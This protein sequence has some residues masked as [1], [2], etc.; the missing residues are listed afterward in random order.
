MTSAS[1][2][3]L[4]RRRLLGLRLR[5]SAMLALVA[6]PL[7]AGAALL[8]A[9]RWALPISS[10]AGWSLVLLP[11]LLVAVA[12]AV[13]G[14]RR[15][16]LPRLLRRLDAAFPETEDSSAL[17]LHD[18]LPGGSLPA[19]Q[20][21]IVRDRLAATLQ[22]P[23]ALR[24]T[25]RPAPN[26]VRLAA[27]WL[28]GAVLIA[29]AIWV[30]AARQTA[31][32][33]ASPQPPKTAATTLLQTVLTV[34]PPAYTGLGVQTLTSPDAA[35]DAKVPAGS[36]VDWSL[37]IDR[38][39]DGAALVWND[40]SRT[41]LVRGS[42]GSSGA[43][44]WQGSRTIDASAL[45]R[46]ELRGAASLVGDPL[47]RID[48][49]PDA[50]PEIS[51]SVPDK[52]LNLLAEG[53]T[54]WAIAFDARDD[55]GL[56]PATLTITLAQGSGEQIKVTGQTRVLEGSGDARHRSYRQ[57]LDL[58]TLGF[59][60][61][62]DL[63]V[64]LDVADNHAPEAQHTSSAG[65]ILRRPADAAAESAGM[66]GLVQ[67]VLPA[68]FRS[69]RQI[70]I[71]TE[72]LIAAQDQLPE[73]TIAA[74]ADGLGVDQK[75][76]R[77][78]YGQFLGEGF[79]SNAERAPPGREA[80]AANR[81]P[82]GAEPGRTAS[83]PDPAGA[84]VDAA[85][86]AALRTRPPEA[87]P[88]P[89]AA[90]PDGKGGRGDVLAEFGHVHD[91][92]EAATLLDPQTQRIL[93]EALG[94]MWQAELMLRQARLREALPFEAKAL[95]AIKQV[96]QAERIYVARAGQ[97]LPQADAARRLSGERKGLTDRDQP[98]PRPEATDSPVPAMWAALA[99]GERPSPEALAALAAWARRPAATGQH[100]DPLALQAAADRLQRAPDCTDCRDALQAALWPLLP[101]PPT[102]VLPRAAPNAIGR[103]YLD[104][105][106]GDAS[107]RA[108]RGRPAEAR[109]P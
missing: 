58:S 45:Y 42:I 65:F 7:A 103:A 27:A 52:T 32:K 89:N 6:M 69:E 31:A 11:P 48:A 107:S 100:A 44:Q 70:I 1:L 10:P 23:A 81:P 55:Y 59:A 91:Q 12:A 95:E 68:Y 9:Q 109:Q 53:Q 33:S 22:D 13:V 43:R 24:R 54:Q 37:A 15:H 87:E 60:K 51:V 77:L 75:V 64:R 63:I 79:E 30:P 50:P 38:D 61:G 4:V 36:R 108:A 49:V 56:G 74:R 57:A 94:A 34:T 88:A 80:A 21:T 26:G 29:A 82:S 96:Q 20:Q 35:L 71:D 16:D 105:L 17:A 86:D 5:E 76:L 73:K 47:R 25:L 83:A 39:A 66:E 19:L 41:P 104:A 18:D 84:R 62:D 90:V 99:R 78:R 98:L 72:A 101:L 8:V 28:A 93:K 92:A 3:R 97:D 106:E 85:A 46:I 2:R 102:G 67:K 40:G 14:T